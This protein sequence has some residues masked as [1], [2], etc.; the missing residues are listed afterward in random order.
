MGYVLALSLSM[1]VVDYLA[2]ERGW[3]RHRW[4][5]VAA[6]WPFL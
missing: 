4:R 2:F 3:S 6:C 5:V 1:F